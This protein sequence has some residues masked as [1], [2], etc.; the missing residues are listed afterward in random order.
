MRRS[1]EGIWGYNFHIL[2]QK[3][4]ISVCSVRVFHLVGCFVVSGT[5]L[6]YGRSETLV[7]SDTAFKGMT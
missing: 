2:T 3:G 6:E 5:K 1:F 4:L 7:V